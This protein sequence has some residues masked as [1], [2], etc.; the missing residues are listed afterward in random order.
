VKRRQI[1]LLGV[2]G[3]AAAGGGMAWSLRRASSEF[4]EGEAAVWDLGFERPEGGTLALAALRGRPLLLNFWATWCAPC[5]KEMPMLDRFFRDKQ[6]SGWSVVG[7][8]VD[9]AEPVRQFLAHLP[10]S[11]PIGLAGTEGVDLSARL[12]NTQGG[13]PFTVA[14]DRSGKAVGRRVGA[15]APTH[16]ERWERAL[17]I[18]T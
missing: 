4:A 18:T 14:F 7:L 17:A 13:L 6:A 11:F 8:A 16:L 2:L 12:G 10:V 1:A 5:V 3:V 15:L 9:Q